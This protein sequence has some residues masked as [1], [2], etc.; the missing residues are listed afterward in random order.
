MTFG[1]SSSQI[2]VQVC[3]PVLGQLWFRQTVVPVVGDEEAMK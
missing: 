3:V 2:V 1:S